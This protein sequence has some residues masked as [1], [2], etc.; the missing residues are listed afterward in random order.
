MRNL[1]LLDRIRCWKR[2]I[3]G[4]WPSSA[5]VPYNK[6]LLLYS[7][8]TDVIFVKWWH[9]IGQN[10]FHL[11][12]NI[13]LNFERLNNLQSRWPSTQ[14]ISQY[15]RGKPDSK[16]LQNIVNLWYEFRASIMITFYRWLVGFDY[17]GDRV[18]WTLT[19]KNHEKLI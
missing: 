12:G 17:I 18:S 9:V 16:K 8:N 7:L 1:N 5:Q 10:V 14:C 15:F 2:V 19:I 6:I 4:I 13:F 11:R 3:L